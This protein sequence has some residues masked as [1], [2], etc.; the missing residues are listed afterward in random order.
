[1][2]RP[3][4][5][6][7]KM[8]NMT[9]R[10][11]SQ[12][13]NDIFAWFAKQDC[14]NILEG[15]VFVDMH[16]HLEVIARAGTGK[17]TT[18]IEGVKRA[19]EQDVLVCAFSKIIADELTL[20]IAGR[21]GAVAKTLHSVGFACIRAYRD[22]L[23]LNP[24][25]NELPRADGLALRVCG[26]TAPD[27]IV[28]MVSKLLTKGREIA[29]HA[30]KLGD[31]TSIAITFECEPD[32]AWENAGFGMVY[33]ETK[34]LEAMEL[35][36]DVKS[37]DLIDFSDMIFLPV[38]NAWL[39]KQYDLVVVDEAQDMTNAQLEVALGV[40]RKGGRVC[41]VGDDRQ[42]IFGFR[43]ADSGSL[44]RLADE[45]SAS[46]LKLATTYR[47][48]KS[49]VGVAQGYVPDFKA[50]ENNTDGEVLAIL[51][52]QLVPMAGPGDFILSRTNA[53]LVATAMK[54]LRSGKR[55]RVA[56]RDIGKG[57]VS[58]VRKLKGRSVPDLLAKIERWSNREIARHDAILAQATNGRRTAIQAK[59]EAISDQ[60]LMLTELADGAKSVDEVTARVESL[61]ASD[62]AVAGTVTCSSVHRSKGLEANRVFILRDTLRS[63]NNEEENIAYVAI[64]RAK[65][66]LVWVDRDND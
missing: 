13:Q 60:A 18:I 33:V 61:F 54:L 42:A 56:G 38:R 65:Q 55:A 64:T 49:I 25:A 31:L 62:G 32:E 40:L 35:A 63:G 14:C 8:A 4:E 43:G 5:Q 58:L 11:W 45:L 26:K 51:M 36:A 1:M 15:P 27:E 23:R 53:P 28:R 6:E 66:S 37:G 12:E 41:I 47:C 22:R 48:G 52:N 16:G 2:R 19:P 24:N 29:P 34:A 50:D 46:I 10:T 57:L 3:P 44:A 9:E 39:T 17:T 7:A 21:K 59:I 30:N 20:R